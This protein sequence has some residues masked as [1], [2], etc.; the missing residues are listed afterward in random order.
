[1]KNSR[2]GGGGQTKNPTLQRKYG[3]NILKGVKAEKAPPVG[4]MSGE[5]KRG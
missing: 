4:L 1:M 3:G 5:S 2:S